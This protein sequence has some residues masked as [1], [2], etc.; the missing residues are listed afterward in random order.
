MNPEVSSRGLVSKYTLLRFLYSQCAIPGSVNTVYNSAVLTLTNKAVWSAYS[1]NFH[2][3]H[4]NS[5]PPNPTPSVYL[6][7]LDLF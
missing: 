3:L 5:I 7:T 2:T 1:G 4:L 6:L